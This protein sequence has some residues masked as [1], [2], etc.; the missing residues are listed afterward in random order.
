MPLSDR[1]D[2]NWRWV[3][4]RDHTYQTTATD[5]KRH[6]SER[7]FSD[8]QATPAPPGWATIA[9]SPMRRDMN[10]TA[11]SGRAIRTFNTRPMAGDRVAG[12]APGWHGF[13]GTLASNSGTR[14]KPGMI[15]TEAKANTVS[16]PVR[17]R[18]H[19]HRDRT[20]TTSAKWS[21]S[22]G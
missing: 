10:P 12:K 19:D 3:S 1:L 2:Q 16:C 15:H 9:A 21:L 14:N 11:S 4:S 8:N 7:Y 6:A 18:S 20:A 5:N 22:I 17:C 13:F